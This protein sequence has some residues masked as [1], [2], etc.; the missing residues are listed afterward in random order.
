MRMLSINLKYKIEKIRQLRHY[1]INYFL[2]PK[3]STHTGLDC[4][5]KLGDEYDIMFWPF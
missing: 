4:E 3:S 5:K 1:K 2:L